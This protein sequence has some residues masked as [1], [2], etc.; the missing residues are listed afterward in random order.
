MSLQRY[1]FVYFTDFQSAILFT[2][3]IIG[4]C[5]LLHYPHAHDPLVS[6]CYSY[7]IR[8]RTLRNWCIDNDY[9]HYGTAVFI[10]SFSVSFI[11]ERTVFVYHYKFILLLS[12]AATQF[13]EILVRYVDIYMVIIYMFQIGTILFEQDQP[14]CIITY[15]MLRYLCIRLTE[16]ETVDV[17]VSIH[18]KVFSDRVL[19]VACYVIEDKNGI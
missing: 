18:R 11:C 12:I 3:G 4:F 2:N 14:I 13:A 15:K 1:F 19:L 10:K 7:C 6:C 9:S 16:I 8:E 5:N 17:R